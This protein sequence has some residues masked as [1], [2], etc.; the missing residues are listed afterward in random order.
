MWWKIYLCRQES[1]EDTSKISMKKI[2][3]RHSIVKM[4]FQRKGKKGPWKQPEKKRACEDNNNCWFHRREQKYDF[5]L[6]CCMWKGRIL[7]AK[8]K[9]EIRIIFMLTKAT[10]ICTTGDA[11]EGLSCR[12][13]GRRPVGNL[14]LEVGRINTISEKGE[15]NHKRQ[16]ILSSSFILQKIDFYKKNPIYIY[17]YI[18]S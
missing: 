7:P 3:L 12:L 16:G 15:I 6:K 9:E 8:K 2:L 14:G 17:M 18:Y 11:M 4:Q 10:A 1:L 5:L 13:K